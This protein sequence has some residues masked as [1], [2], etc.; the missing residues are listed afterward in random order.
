MLI[1]QT[2]KPA[3]SQCYK[4]LCDDYEDLND[5]SYDDGIPKSDNLHIVL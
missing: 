1:V 2:K 3:S 4:L 5:D